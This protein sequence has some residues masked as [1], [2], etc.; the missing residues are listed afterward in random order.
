[1]SGTLNQ[2]KSFVVVVLWPSGRRTR[3][4]PLPNYAAAE[5]FG[6]RAVNH[7][8]AVSFDVNRQIGLSK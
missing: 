3:Y 2:I 7:L 6:R 1:M 8:G 4:S 5:S